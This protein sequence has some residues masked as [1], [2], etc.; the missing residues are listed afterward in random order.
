MFMFALSLFK[1][2][3]CWLLIL[4]IILFNKPWACA[5]IRSL[6]YVWLSAIL[7]TIV[8]QAPLSMGFLRQEYWSGLPFL[9]PG[10]LPDPGI[11]PTSLV[12]P[13]LAGRFF[14][15]WTTR[16]ALKRPYSSWN[17]VAPAWVSK[18]WLPFPTYSLHCSLN[19]IFENIY[20]IEV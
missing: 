11:K 18:L 20:F 13:A 5:G 16:E 3:H 9:P 4:E 12:S 19:I 14:I 15:S 1:L 17:D 7:G 2:C 8:C 10:H 6:S